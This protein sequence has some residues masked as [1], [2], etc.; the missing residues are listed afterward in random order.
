V[1]R[2]LVGILLL[3]LSAAL[4]WAAAKTLAGVALGASAAAPFVAGMGLMAVSWVLGRHVIDPIGPF[5]WGTR[6]ARWLYVLGHELTHALAAW[7]SGGKVFAI[8]VEEKGGH[9]DLSRSSAFV[10]LAPY[11]VP[12]HALLVVAGYRALLWLKPEAQAEAL[13]LLL[14]GGALAFHALMTW[15][16]LTRVR[17][18]DLDD[19]GGRVFSF[20][21]IVLA[22]GLVVLLLLKV[23]FLESVE[24][25]AALKTAGLRAWWFW[26]KAWALAWPEAKDLWRRSRA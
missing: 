23:L 15:E 3:P 1:L 8:H 19:A 11:C 22:N 13:F 21:L 6:A 12:F 2:L 20:A 10:A 17:Q 24:L 26:T 25:G 16:T 18:P 7:T 9:V 5:G 14:M 4:F